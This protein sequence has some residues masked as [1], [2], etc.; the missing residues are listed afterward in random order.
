MP[1]LFLSLLFR[2][3]LMKPALILF[4]LVVLPLLFPSPSG[5]VAAATVDSASLPILTTITNPSGTT[6]AASIALYPTAVT[7]SRIQAS[8]A[9]PVFG[10]A[11]ALVLIA[12]I[13]IYRV[14]HSI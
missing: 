5:S 11:G 14:Y 10:I 9:Y 7:L 12:L 2:V 6:I 13:L 4:L 8:P 1:L 3:Y